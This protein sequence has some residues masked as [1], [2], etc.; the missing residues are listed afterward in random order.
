VR[1]RP[2][3]LTV[4]SVH[5]LELI[6]T[7]ALVKNR[8]PRSDCFFIQ[9]LANYRVRRPARLARPCV[10]RH[11]IIRRSCSTLGAGITST[12][13]IYSFGEGMLCSIIAYFSR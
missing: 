11:L 5:T 8:A 2:L 13:V 7:H 9:S 4:T 6:P 3:L 12:A 1:Y 10:S